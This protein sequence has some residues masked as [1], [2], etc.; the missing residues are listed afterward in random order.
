MQF[1]RVYPVLTESFIYNPLVRMDQRQIDVQ[2]LT[3]VKLPR[4]VDG[5]PVRRLFSLPHFMHGMSALQRV[6]GGSFQMAELDF[7]FA[8]LLDFGLKRQVKRYKPDV[9]HAHFGPEGCMVL[10]VARSLDIPLVVSFYGY[11]VTKLI[12]MA[13][14]RWRR[15]YRFLF[16]HADRFI[17]IS[18]HIAERLVEL[19]A[20]PKKIV[21][22]H[23]GSDV[24][25]FAY[26]DP[27]ERYDGKTVRCMHVGR[28][29][30]KKAPLHLLDAFD[31]A[32]K[33]LGEAGPSLHLTMAGDGELYSETKQHIESLGLQSHVELLGAVLHSRVKE[34]LGKANLYTQHCV[35]TR[36]GDTEGL[37]LSFVEASARGLPVVSTRHNGIPEVVLHGKTGLLSE[38]HDIE[39]MANHICELAVDPARWTAMGQ[40]GRAHIESRFSVDHAIDAQFAVYEQAI[41]DHEAR[42]LTPAV[43]LGG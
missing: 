36:S 15:K 19:G 42:R 32:R 27:A 33:K 43:G 8:K 22:V 30:E 41:L 29:T 16:R 2:M 6:G 26:S 3:V 11:D 7:W 10:P 38:E 18:D 20:S 31:L 1:R 40:A 34:E 21:K 13:G 17:A 23:L 37:G 9:I 4:R 39:A 35:T 24:T 25:D 12:T 28:L 5:P 14:D